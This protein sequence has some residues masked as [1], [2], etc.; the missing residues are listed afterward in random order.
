M[1]Q[2]HCSLATLS[3]L[4]CSRNVGMEGGGAIAK[5]IITKKLMVQNCIFKLKVYTQH[6]SS[7]DECN[8]PGHYLTEYMA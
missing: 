7:Y 2:L 1:K 8:A 3:V 5:I 6:Y 4:Y